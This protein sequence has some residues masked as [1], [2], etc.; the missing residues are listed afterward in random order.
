MDVLLVVDMATAAVDDDCTAVVA[1]SDPPVL[2]PSIVVRAV[3][4]RPPLPLDDEEVPDDDD[5]AEVN[6]L[7]PGGGL[8]YR[9]K[10][11][12]NNT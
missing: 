11:T 6:G 1:R 4:P 8:E 5:V 10:I 3:T 7:Q 9:V 2:S 12:T